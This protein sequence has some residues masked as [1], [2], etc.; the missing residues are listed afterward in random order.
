M[1]SPMRKDTSVFTWIIGE[2]QSLPSVGSGLA[3]HHHDYVVRSSRLENTIFRVI[4]NEITLK[5]TINQTR[6][7][8]L[9]ISFILV[10]SFIQL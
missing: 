3:M 8:K 2:L 1:S 7:I 10:F 9:V 6:D 4:H 5:R